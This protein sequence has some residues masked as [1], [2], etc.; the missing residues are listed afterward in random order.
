MKTIEIKNFRGEV[1]FKHES[2]NN[3]IKEAVEIAV[4]MELA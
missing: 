1:I 4:K 3:T 2:E